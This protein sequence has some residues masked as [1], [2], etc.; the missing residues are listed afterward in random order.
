M[1]PPFLGVKGVVAAGPSSAAPLL[2]FMW[3]PINGHGGPLLPHPRPAPRE[4]EQADEEQAQAGQ[5]RA[6]APEGHDGLAQAEP[7]AD[8]GAE[9]RRPE[10]RRAA[11]PS[12]SD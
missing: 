9:E 7:G 5:D 10:P 4:A 2:P 6:L 12:G 3:S 1:Q 8:G 11:R